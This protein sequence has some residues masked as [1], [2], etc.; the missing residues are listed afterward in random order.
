MLLLELELFDRHFTK[1]R[2]FEN[3]HIVGDLGKGLDNPIVHRI[4]AL[5]IF[6]PRQS[7]HNGGMISA[8]ETVTNFGESPTCNSSHHRRRHL[9][10]VHNVGLARLAAEIFRCQLKGFGNK[11]T[12]FDQCWG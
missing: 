8:T 3:T 6:D 10:R 11:I 4:N 7:V 2:N 9:P 5:P 12:N 1:G